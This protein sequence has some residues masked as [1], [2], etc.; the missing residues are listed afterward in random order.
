MRATR[1][2]RAKF[3]AAVSLI[4]GLAACPFPIV[5]R[6]ESW[7][8]AFAD[9][10]DADFLLDGVTDGFRYQFFDPE[11][12]GVFYKVPN[13]VP[14]VHAPKVAAW[15]AAETVAGRYA[16]IRQAFARG[17][18]ALG[19]VD[20]DNSNMAKVRVVHDLSRPIGTSTNLGITIE[21]CSLPSS[22]SKA[23]FL[24]TW[25]I[26]THKDYGRLLNENCGHGPS[27]KSI[28]KIMAVYETKI[29]DMIHRISL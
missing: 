29:V 7:H 18:A 11:P 21:H 4:T 14:D 9:D 27:R 28:D 22:S 2:R 15:V 20:K 19:V 6:A 1:V 26:A 8:R 25:S 17:F 12:D 23:T 24:W 16:P 13:Y 5:T 3:V 10:H